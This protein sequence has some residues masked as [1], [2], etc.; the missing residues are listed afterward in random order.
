MTKFLQRLVQIRPAEISAALWAAAYFFFVLCGYYL[1]RPI[2]DNMGIAGG[3]RN[4]PWLF[5]GTLLAMLVLSPLFS[6]LVARLPRRRFIALSYRLSMLCLVIFFMLFRSLPEDSLIVA[7]RAFYIWTSVFNL[8]VVSV[9]WGFAADTFRPEQGRRLF[10]FLGVGGTLGA[11][12]GSAIVSLVADRIDPAWLMLLAV[13]LLEVAV[14]CSRKAGRVAREH[15][16]PKQTIGGGALAGISH[17][18]RSPYLLG[19]CSYILLYTILATFLYFQQA[20]IVE[21]VLTDSGARTALFA[22]IDLAVNILTIL[23]QIFLT[24]RIIRL[25]GVG[26]TL[27]LLPLI[28][29]IGFTSIGLV[30]TLTAIIL[31]QVVRRSG[32]YALARPAREVLFT[33][34]PRED[35]YKAKN[36]I[37][38]FVYR[39]GDQIG[40]WS[41]ALL[42]WAGIGI[43]WVSI[44]AV[45]L[46]CL[47]VAVAIWLG[48]KLV[49]KQGDELKGTS[50]D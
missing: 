5:T 39:G 46:A 26:L 2:R 31:F 15:E 16:P 34:L 40:A 14:Q 22:K 18:V 38:T 44:V 32:N 24:G 17:V 4:L 1:L 35:K 25:L 12:C 33:V 47:W 21:S 8:F 3:V 36:F 41:W 49:N 7:G 29:V 50:Q 42:G 27:A 9:F 37:D 20:S 6:S 10:G 30:P 11:I 48:S 28:C 23:T 19:I 13:L 43:A 45:P